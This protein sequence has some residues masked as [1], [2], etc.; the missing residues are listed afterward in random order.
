VATLRAI[1]TAVAVLDGLVCLYAL[2][3]ACALTVQERR[4]TLAVLRACGA[5]GGAVSRLLAGAVMA[6]VIPAAAVG[7][8]L[9]QLVLA[10]AL[11]R[12]AASYATLPISASEAE[13]AAVLAGAAAAG[14]I[15]V[16]SV[17]REVARETVVEGLA[18]T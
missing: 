5:G 18:A 6:L 17:G 16:V 1:L 13:I 3:Q 12:L 4:P 9:E 7:I 2:L 8:V 10:P 14:A 15:A 11:S